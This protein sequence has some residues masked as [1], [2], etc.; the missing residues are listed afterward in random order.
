MSKDTYIDWLKDAI[1]N[2]HV[3]RYEYLEFKDEQP[4]GNGSYGNVCR[5]NWKNKDVF[6]L[7]S[8]NNSREVIKEIVKELKLHRKVSYHK[9][10]IRLYGITMEKPKCWKD[11]PDQRPD[12]QNVVFILEAII[13]PNQSATLIDNNYEDES[14][15]NKS[16]PSINYD[17]KL[18]DLEIESLDNLDQNSVQLG[19]SYQFGIGTKEGDKNL[20][21]WYAENT[22][23]QYKIV[24]LKKMFN[25]LIGKADIDDLSQVSI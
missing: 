23:G 14:D 1:D 22:K 13:S 17:S 7:K 2:E 20:Y 6:A 15:S 25:N 10:I 16:K 11:E 4:I 18:I 19:H 12:I 21:N 8:F 3:K 5:V 24:S 9:N